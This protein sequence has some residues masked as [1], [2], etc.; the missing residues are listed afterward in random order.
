MACKTK[1]YII[2]YVLDELINKSDEIAEKIAKR[3]NKSL[4]EVVKSLIIKFSNLY[5]KAE[6]ISLNE[7]DEESLKE[8]EKIV[9]W[10]DPKDI[11]IPALAL[12][13]RKKTGREINILSYDD[14]LIE[15]ACKHGIKVYKKPKCSKHQI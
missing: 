8:A 1:Y 15:E 2:D 7:I 14:D 13:L 4:P 6:I 5:K 10:R 11:P 12:A 9:G 3:S